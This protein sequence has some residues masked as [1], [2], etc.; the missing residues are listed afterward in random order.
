M[1]GESNRPTFGGTIAV[2]FPRESGISSS[3]S[4]RSRP[5]SPDSIA[6]STTSS[7]STLSSYSLFFRDAETAD[8][9]TKAIFRFDDA[10]TYAALQ[11]CRHVNMRIEKYGDLSTAATT[12]TSPL[13]HFHLDL[14][15]SPNLKPTQRT[16]MEFDL[17]ERLDLG[18]SEKGVVGR[19]VT[20]SDAGGAILG[21]GIVG[22]N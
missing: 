21:V 15:Q 18:V 8:R 9:K 17:P 3:A 13:H 11:E 14:A 22:Y 19:Q 7:T 6:S 10:E 20:L 16:D 2:L 1:C 12:T 4:E 5:S